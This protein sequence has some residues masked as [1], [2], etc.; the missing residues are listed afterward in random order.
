VLIFGSQLNKHIIRISLCSHTR[1]VRVI[2]HI[3][4]AIYFDV[5]SC[6]IVICVLICLNQ[7]YQISE[8]CKG[9]LADQLYYKGLVNLFVF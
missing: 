8:E 3:L 5:G 6:D 1:T 9:I 4:Y 2:V 7:W